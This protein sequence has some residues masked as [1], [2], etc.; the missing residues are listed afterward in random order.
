MKHDVKSVVAELKRVG[1]PS[2]RS[3]FAVGA[4]SSVIPSRSK[5]AQLYVRDGSRKSAKKSS[6][7]S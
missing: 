4:S 1:F 5:K 6:E 7:R 3:I 2:A